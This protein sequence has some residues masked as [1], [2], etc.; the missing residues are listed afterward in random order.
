MQPRDGLV[1]PC[2]KMRC[3]CVHPGAGGRSSRDNDN[4]FNIQDE[5]IQNRTDLTFKV[6][7]SAQVS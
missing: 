4:A 1:V 7:S 6:L 5:G 2:Q 3:E